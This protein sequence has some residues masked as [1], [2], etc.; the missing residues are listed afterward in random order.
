MFGVSLRAAMTALLM[1]PLA[2][3]LGRILEELIPLFNAPDSLLATTFTAVSDYAL[4]IG[5]LGAG[6]MLV[7]SAVTE[8]EVA[9]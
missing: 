2:A 9:R 4:A 3:I 7:A 8:S 5:L 1:P 6:M